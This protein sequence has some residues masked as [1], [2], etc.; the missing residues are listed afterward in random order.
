MVEDSLPSL[1][2]LRKRLADAEP[3]LLREMMRMVVTA[4]MGAE[5]DE[6]CGAA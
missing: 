3:D 4:L 2:W 1:E 6:L 5:A